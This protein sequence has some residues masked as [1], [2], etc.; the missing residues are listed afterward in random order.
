MKEDNHMYC[1][2]QLVYN[3]EQAKF[4]IN[5]KGSHKS[6]LSRQISKAVRIRRR[7]GESWIL[8]SKAEYNRCHIPQLKM[9]EE[10]EARKREEEQRLQELNK[11]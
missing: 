5:V 7:A 1:H 10:Q 8:N 6:A 3:G 11:D 9:E 4:S 2:Q